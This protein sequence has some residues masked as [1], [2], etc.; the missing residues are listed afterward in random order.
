[1]KNIYPILVIGIFILSGFG[2]SAE[3]IFSIDVNIEWG[4]KETKFIYYSTVLES[5]EN[6]QR[7]D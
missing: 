5:N 7:N 3:S 2:A 1:M 6:R 4:Q